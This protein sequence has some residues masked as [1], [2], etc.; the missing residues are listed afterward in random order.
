MR[1]MLNLPFSYG[2]GALIVLQ[3]E[4]GG[5]VL[6]TVGAGIALDTILRT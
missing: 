3:K 2:G 5:S 1:E 6:E 4:G